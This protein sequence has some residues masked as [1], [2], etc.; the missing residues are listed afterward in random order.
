MNYISFIH[1][2]IPVQTVCKMC[3]SCF[4]QPGSCEEKQDNDGDMSTQCVDTDTR[5][6]AASSV[7]YQTSS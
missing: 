3:K 7:Q 6:V 1:D 2:N 4:T 5:S